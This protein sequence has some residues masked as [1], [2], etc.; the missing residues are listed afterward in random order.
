ME[1]FNR[2]INRITAR[3]EPEPVAVPESD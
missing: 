1:G 2:C 3:T